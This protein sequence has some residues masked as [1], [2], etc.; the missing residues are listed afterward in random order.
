MNWVG[1]QTP[2]FDSFLFSILP[3]QKIYVHEGIERRIIL[4]AG[5]DWFYIYPQGIQDLLEYTTEK[6]NNPIIYITENGMF[7]YNKFPI[8]YF[9][10]S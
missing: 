8:S 1:F 6:Y 3:S 9:L 10:K 2:I 7:I 5:S 4:Q